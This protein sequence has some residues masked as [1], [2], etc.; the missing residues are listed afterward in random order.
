M[1]KT[2]S[3]SCLKCLSFFLLWWKCVLVLT[4]SSHH[5]P[6]SPGDARANPGWFKF[7]HFLDLELSDLGYGML[8]RREKKI[9]RHR[10]M[11]GRTDGWINES[12]GISSG[13]AMHTNFYHH[14][15]HLSCLEREG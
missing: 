10:L 9:A 14:K 7:S 2:D 5:L 3:L 1:L 13:S 6:T 8:T 15:V 11:D 4:L 12:T